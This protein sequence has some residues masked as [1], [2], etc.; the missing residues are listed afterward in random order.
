MMI[1]LG[2]QIELEVTK[3]HFWRIVNGGEEYSPVETESAGL[4]EAD[5]QATAL[6]A[7]GPVESV[8]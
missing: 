3:E 6:S 2:D 5:P 8:K 4:N 1:G 7:G